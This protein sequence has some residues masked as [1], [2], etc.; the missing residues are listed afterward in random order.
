MADF[1]RQTIDNDTATATTDV[2]TNG[3]G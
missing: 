3:E 2:H 1:I